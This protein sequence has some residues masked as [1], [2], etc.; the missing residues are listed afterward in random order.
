MLKTNDKLVILGGVYGDMILDAEGV[1]QLASLP[2]LGRA[3]F[4][5]CW[6][7]TGACAEN[8]PD[9]RQIPGT[10]SWLVLPRRTARK[11]N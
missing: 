4:E 7:A 1:K 8:C 5:D 10:T 3:S 6:F 11:P 2:S 9:Y